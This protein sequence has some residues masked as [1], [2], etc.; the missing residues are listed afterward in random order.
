MTTSRYIDPD[1]RGYVVIRGNYQRTSAA[2]AWVYLA[3]MTIRGSVPGLPRFGSDLRRLTHTYAGIT[4]D[5]IRMID[6]VMRPEVGK[7]F[8]DYRRTCWL[9]HGAPVF[10]VT[11]LSGEGGAAVFTIPISVG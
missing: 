1:T 6:E 10:Q 3:L 2:A 4:K 7:R 8:A 5:I 11:I 9:Q